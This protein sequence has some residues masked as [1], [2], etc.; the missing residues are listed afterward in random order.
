MCRPA[1]V[2]LGTWLLEAFAVGV[3]TLI[4]RSVMSL[5]GLLLSLVGVALFVL[6][7]LVPIKSSKTSSN[8]SSSLLIK[9][10]FV[11]SFSYEFSI[12]VDYVLI[13]I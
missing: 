12:S 7:L 6:T 2:T 1:L 8:N 9:S 13:S 5:L 4:V 10:I 11:T 3:V